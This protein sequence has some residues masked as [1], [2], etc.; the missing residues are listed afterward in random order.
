MK[1]C[2]LP[3]PILFRDYSRGG[4]EEHRSTAPP[5]RGQALGGHRHQK[6]WSDFSRE[7][8]SSGM[9]LK[10]GHLGPAPQLEQLLSNL[11][12]KMRVHSV[13]SGWPCNTSHCQRVIHA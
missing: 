7:F 13:G 9:E 4:G 10:G 12:S 11:F 2:A 1:T 5:L 8:G 6:D 3:F